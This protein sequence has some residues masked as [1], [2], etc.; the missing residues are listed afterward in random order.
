MVPAPARIAAAPRTNSRP[1]C[2]PAV[3]PPPVTGAPVGNEELG[4]GDGLGLALELGDGLVEA[5]VDELAAGRGEGRAEV[6]AEVL[7]VA[8][9]LALVE[10][11]EV[12]VDETVALTEPPDGVNTDDG[13]EPDEQAETPAAPRRSKPPQPR[14]VR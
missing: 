14:A 11:V 8:L 3:P 10:E 6:L 2:K 7:A 5:G 4:D 13:V 1:S 9:V 12:D